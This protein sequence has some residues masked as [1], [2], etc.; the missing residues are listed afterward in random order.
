MSSAVA[1]NGISMPPYFEQRQAGSLSEIVEV[2]WCKVP[3]LSPPLLN[4]ILCLLENPWTLSD[5]NDRKLEKFLD[6]LYKL[7]TLDD[8]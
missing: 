1:R 3:P 5:L 6:I 4:I 2:Q 8:P 7:L